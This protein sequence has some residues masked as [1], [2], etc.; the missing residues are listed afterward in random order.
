[1][2]PLI[3]S[4]RYLWCST[5]NSWTYCGPCLDDVAK[6][7]EVAKVTT[8]V[9]KESAEVAK[10]NTEVAKESTEVA[11]E[12]T[13]VAKENTEVAKENQGSDEKTETKEVF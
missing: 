9:A 12:S 7:E 8:P 1:M 13:E 4:G 10:E 3:K 2:L 5:G 11:K 6:E